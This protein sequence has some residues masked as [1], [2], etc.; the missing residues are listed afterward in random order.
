MLWLRVSVATNATIFFE[1]GAMSVYEI[2]VMGTD[3]KVWRNVPAGD[4]MTPAARVR[5]TWPR[6]LR[7]P[8][9]A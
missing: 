4:K 8:T 6:A 9:G 5:H 7:R 2:L 1:L 3:F